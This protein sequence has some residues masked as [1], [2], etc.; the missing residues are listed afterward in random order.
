MLTFKNREELIDYLRPEREL[1][2]LQDGDRL[3]AMI[4]EVERYGR[5]TTDTTFELLALRSQ[6][7]AP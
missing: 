3:L 4:Q 1:L 7:K 6:K 2:P 5:I